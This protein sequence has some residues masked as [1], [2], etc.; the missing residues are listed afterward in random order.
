MQLAEV[1]AASGIRR[2]V[3][4]AARLEKMIAHAD[5]MATAWEGDQLIGVARAITDFSYCC[6][7]S[8]LAVAGPFQR[9]GVGR[10]LI[11]AI[12]A[13][14]SDEVAIILVAAPGAEH[15][16]PHVGFEKIASAWHLPRAR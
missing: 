15:Y 12:R 14:V 13:G 8:D 3:H 9:R 6:Y 11:E 4:D 16:Y 7:L 1:F 2:P 10:R 5:L